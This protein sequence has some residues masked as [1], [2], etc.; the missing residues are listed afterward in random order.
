MLQKTRLSADSALPGR[1]PSRL[2]F[3]RV[4]RRFGPI[5]ALKAF[6]LDIAPSEI[7]CLL[8]PSGCGKTTALRI[9]A[10]VD[11]PSEG[12][13]LLDGN[14]VAGPSRFVAPEMRGVGLMFQDFAL[15]PH[16]TVLQNV[17][18]GLRG[19]GSAETRREAVAALDRVGL[20]HYAAEYPHILSGGEQQRVA[21]ARAIAPRPS[22]LL[23]DEPFSGLDSR[24]RETT[25]D[26]TLA[27]L[28][29][30]KATC[31]IVTHAPNEALRMGDRIAVMRGG[32]IIQCGTADALYNEPRDIDVAR[33]FSRMNEFGGRVVSGAVA[34][35]LGAIPAPG[36]REG[37]EAVVC[38]RQSAMRLG[39]AGRG[40]GA[41]IRAVRFLGDTALVELG[42]E[43]C[44]EPL[45]AQLA[46]AEA[47]H[48]GEVVGL[49]IAQGGA[50]VFPA[51]P[52]VANA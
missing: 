8:G 21:L 5:T 36:V 37:S 3:D 42:V 28:R 12:R 2:T 43:G 18:F 11:H 7:V 52:S 15:F 29:E 25:R 10:G 34:S 30:T 4:N 27:I 46:Q 38:V 19:L 13:I 9:A 51:E 41:Q 39:A 50:M 45:V 22:V 1:S 44:D 35:P 23:M 47:P 40:T 16:L 20:A 26:D 32:T 49:S 31:V 17:A 6:S 24:L 48:P 14:E 33:T